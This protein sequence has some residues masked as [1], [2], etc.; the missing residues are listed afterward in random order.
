MMWDIPAIARR[1]F[2]VQ[3]N[4]RQEEFKR[5]DPFNLKHIC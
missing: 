1:M 5:M 3:F 2:L 4:K